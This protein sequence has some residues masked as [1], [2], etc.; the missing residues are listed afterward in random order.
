MILFT[1]Y[2]SFTMN[3]VWWEWEKKPKTEKSENQGKF[4]HLVALPSRRLF[5]GVRKHQ[6]QAGPTLDGRGILA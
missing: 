2:N 4:P 3:F 6:K 1:I 5:S